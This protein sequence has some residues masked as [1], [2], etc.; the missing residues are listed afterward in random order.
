[1]KSWKF[2]LIVAITALLAGAAT[3]ATPSQQPASGLP[4]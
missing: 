4:N 3:A 2:A 1:M